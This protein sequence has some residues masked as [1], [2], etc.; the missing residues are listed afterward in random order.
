MVTSLDADTGHV[1]KDYDPA[2]ALPGTPASVVWTKGGPQLAIAYGIR[3]TPKGPRLERQAGPNT[4]GETSADDGVVELV[5][6]D[7]GESRFTAK[8]PPGE[9]PA[10]PRDPVW[11]IAWKP[12]GAELATVHVD[13]FVRT[14]DA[15]AGRQLRRLPIDS[16]FFLPQFPIGL[17]TGALAWAPDGKSMAY[18]RKDSVEIWEL[19]EDAKGR[20]WRVGS[21]TPN[22]IHL[23]SLAWSPDSRRLATL[24]DRVQ[25]AVVQV[26]E[27][28]TGKE[29]FSWNLGGQTAAGTVGLIAWSPD[30]KR[31]AAG[32]KS[33]HVWDVDKGQEVFE[34]SGPT[35]A[36]ARVEWSD[37]GG[38]IAAR[39]PPPDKPNDPR[40]ELVVW[41]ADT[42][43]QV[44]AV[45]GPAA[46][47]LPGPGWTWS[48]TA[49][50]SGDN[51]VRIVNTAPGKD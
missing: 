14:W 30:G 26:W 46:G 47:V 48:A 6:L 15:V 24:A 20:T 33:V 21:A 27:A 32:V 40:Q 35:G 29:L 50:T 3:W 18:I 41:D 43:A 12:D 9:S 13:G 25:N 38:R 28:S 2:R 39:T 31:V 22:A 44:L 36:L 49:P 4:I 16:T 19:T 10:T 11:A 7:K 1:I 5:D 37:D 17:V 8:E 23:L 45:H 34:L 51:A 42:G